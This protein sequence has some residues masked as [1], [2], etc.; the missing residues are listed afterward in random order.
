MSI[1]G[2]MPRA[3]ER[4]Q[5]VGATAL[6]VFVKSNRQWRA[7]ELA[8]AEVGAFREVVAAAGLDRALLAHASYL[9]NLASGV[10]ALRE[11]SL[12]AL[13]IELDRCARLYNPYHWQ[14]SKAVTQF[15]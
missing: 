5:D 6:Q 2:G 10:R 8:D 4:A 3:V 9:I 11:R 7:R 14:R 13:G 12:R 15:F 1:A